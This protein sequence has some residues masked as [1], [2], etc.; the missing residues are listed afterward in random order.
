MHWGW[1]AEDNKHK[2]PTGYVKLFKL[3][4]APHR[5]QKNL[6][7]LPPGVT[8]ERCIS[9]FLRLMKEFALKKVQERA[10]GLA[11]DQ[12]SRSTQWCLTVPAIWEENGKDAMK[13][14]AQLA[15]MTASA[16]NPAGS[17][18]PVLIVLEP[19]AASLLCARDRDFQGAMFGIRFALLLL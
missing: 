7:P 15:G 2:N 18:F 16:A 1:E 9:D 13:R 11:P 14:C 3:Y 17:A 5:M 12:I 4:I 8:A 19:E 10:A 6:Y